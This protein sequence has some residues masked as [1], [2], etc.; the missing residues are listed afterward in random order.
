MSAPRHP[1][2]D[3][4]YSRSERMLGRS[5]FGD[6]VLVPI[7]D[8][9]ADADG[10]FDLNPPAAFIWEQLDGRRDGHAIVAALTERFDVE[11]ARAEEDFLAF[12]KTLFSIGALT[13]E[14]APTT[15]RPTREVR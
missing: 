4:V 3:A 14:A 6:Y 13:S 2:L 12:L 11:P 15:A 8:R 1:S 9:A 7:V 10:I 5:I